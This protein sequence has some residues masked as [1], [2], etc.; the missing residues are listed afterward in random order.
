VAESFEKSSWQ[1]WARLTQSALAADIAITADDLLLVRG[2]DGGT[3][4]PMEPPP[5]QVARPG[6][7]LVLLYPDGDDLRLPLTVRSDRLPN[8]R[9]EVSLP[10]GATDPEDDGPVATA[11]REC[12][13]EL[14]VDPASIT[15]WGGL[16]PI[17]IPPSNFRIAPVIGFCEQPP[18]FRI[19]DAEVSALI[20]VTLGE[21]LDPT[22]V[23]SE[24]WTLRGHEVDVPFFAIAGHKVWGA[25]ALMLSE[26]VARIRQTLPPA[27]THHLPA[28]HDASSKMPIHGANEFPGG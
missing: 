21:L 7:V 2:P 8:H 24:R 12:H 1:W 18:P 28:R 10:G 4:R 17:Y 25:T 5:G 26:L 9:G 11:L 15:I 13:E 22:V 23:V 20:T 3:F 16:A 6:A 19:N 27:D 14:G